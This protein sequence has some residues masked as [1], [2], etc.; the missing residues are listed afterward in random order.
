MKTITLEQVKQM[1]SCLGH[2][3]VE[4]LW[5][6]IRGEGE[7]G[8]SADT[9]ALIDVMSKEHIVWLLM[10]PECLEESEILSLSAWLATEYSVEDKH[11]PGLT[12]REVWLAMRPSIP[13]N[14]VTAQWTALND[15]IY[16]K[17]MEFA[18]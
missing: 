16:N 2:P 17:I 7:T 15:R 3:K 4:E 9:H 10:R 14:E 13:D 1:C 12:R 18:E 11:D 6:T 5:N 8:T